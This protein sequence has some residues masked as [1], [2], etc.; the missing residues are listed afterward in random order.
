M[1]LKAEPISARFD[2]IEAERGRPAAVI[3]MSP[4]GVRRRNTGAS[5]AGCRISCCCAADTKGWTR[6]GTGDQG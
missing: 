1:V 4:Q 3:L 2:A 5:L 6:N